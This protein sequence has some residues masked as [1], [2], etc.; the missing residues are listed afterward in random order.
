[1]I[2]FFTGEYLI[3]S[4]INLE[5]IKAV[6]E[7]TQEEFCFSDSFDPGF[8]SDLCQWG[9]LPMA[10]MIEE[11]PVLLIKLHEYRSILEFENLHIPKN[12]K[13]QSR[14]YSLS[15]DQAFDICVENINNQHWDSWLYP[16]LVQSMSYIHFNGSYKTN[17]HSIE[18]WDNDELIAGELGY[19]VG[20]VYTSLSGFY[21]RDSAGTIQLCATARLLEYLGYSYWDLGMDM[22]YKNKLGAVAFKRNSFLEK[23][24]EAV[25][26][27]SSLICK[28]KN[29]REIID[30]FW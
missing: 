7:A 6:L 30:F 3:D 2:Y 28:Y 21:N 22:A 9:F 17:F 20:S 23:H 18:L 4:D 15:V 5:N 1:M 26:N 27:Q 25:K 29:A 11:I 10:M 12:V 19:S 8:I 13:K 16:S 14:K 24:K